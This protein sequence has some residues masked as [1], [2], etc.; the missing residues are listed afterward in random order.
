MPKKKVV[1]DIEIDIKTEKVKELKKIIS[2]KRK[3]NPSEMVLSK[4]K[5]FKLFKRNKFH[6]TYEIILTNDEY[7]EL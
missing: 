6:K 1:K 7:R 3:L 5:E 2:K 4:A